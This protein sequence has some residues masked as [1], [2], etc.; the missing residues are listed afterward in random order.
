MWRYYIDRN[1]KLK[2]QRKV[3]HSDQ[4]AI[5]QLYLNYHTIH[6]EEIDNPRVVQLP[7][8]HQAATNMTHYYYCNVTAME[9]DRRFIQYIFGESQMVDLIHHRVEYSTIIQIKNT[10][11]ATLHEQLIAPLL[12][13]TTKEEIEALGKNVF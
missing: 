7:T 6:F 12:N 8:Q 10:D 5:G 4:N 11:K 3:A 2:S 1:R 13:L 9:E